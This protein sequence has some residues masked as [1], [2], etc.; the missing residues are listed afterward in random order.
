VDVKV[1]TRAGSGTEGDLKKKN[2][3]KNNGRDS[4][5]SC[6]GINRCNVVVVIIIVS[7]AMS[8]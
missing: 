5:I 8:E 1:S 3:K 7:R 4:E 6:Q 2:N